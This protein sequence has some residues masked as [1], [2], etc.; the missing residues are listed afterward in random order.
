MSSAEAAVAGVTRE[1]DPAGDPKTGR[2]H[3]GADVT[4]TDG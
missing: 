2:N 4:G 1:H 3:A